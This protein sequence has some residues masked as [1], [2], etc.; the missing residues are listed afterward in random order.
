MRKCDKCKTEYDE[1]LKGAIR[2]YCSKKCGRSDYYLKNKKIESVNA[3]NWYQR[4]KDSETA[5]N[6][7]YRKQKRELFDWYHNKD[8]FDGMREIILSRDN[9]TCRACSSKKRIVIHHKDGSGQKRI[10]DS[11]LKTNNDINNLI[12]LCHSCHM[13]LH[14]W[15]RKNKIILSDD[16]E[17]IKVIKKLKNI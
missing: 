16:E 15:Q 13:T 11:E 4:N 14:H 9:N 10:K 7:E 8:R 17:I 2:K 5:K 6:R 12:C 1:T 3:A